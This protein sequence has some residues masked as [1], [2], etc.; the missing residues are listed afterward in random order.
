LQQRHR[1]ARQVVNQTAQ[2]AGRQ[3]ANAGVARMLR[4]NGTVA[5]AVAI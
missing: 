5:V 1:P 2:P 4:R 3:R